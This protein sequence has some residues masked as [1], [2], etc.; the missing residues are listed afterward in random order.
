MVDPA[1][2]G[3]QTLEDYC[4]AVMIGAVAGTAG[5]ATA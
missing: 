4:A 2:E 5:P 3:G 1:G